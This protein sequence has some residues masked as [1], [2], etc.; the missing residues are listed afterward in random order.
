MTS[1]SD[2]VRVFKAEGEYEQERIAVWCGTEWLELEAQSVEVMD[3]PDGALASIILPVHVG[4][5]LTTPR[6]AKKSLPPAAK[7]LGKILRGEEDEQSTELVSDGKG[8]EIEFRSIELDG[9]G[10]P[11][12]TAPRAPVDMD[13]AR[14]HVE[15][16]EAKPALPTWGDQTKRVRWFT[17]TDATGKVYPN[18]ST[19]FAGSDAAAAANVRTRWDKLAAGKPGRHAVK[20]ELQPGGRTAGDEPVA[21]PARASEDDV[22]NVG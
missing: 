8:G 15:S 1:S 4:H 10:A 14:D 3:G 2:R 19:D 16:A 12:A 18:H 13:A 9:F 21:P 5:D 11:I 7:R 17:I 20:V 22:D 6:F